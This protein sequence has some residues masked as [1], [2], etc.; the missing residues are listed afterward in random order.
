M[1]NL[2]YRS[3][4]IKAMLR[5]QLGDL[6][7]VHAL[8]WM[9]PLNTVLKLASFSSLYLINWTRNFVHYYIWARI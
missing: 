7:T 1:T 6:E 9:M 5:L 3:L 2:F 4:Y 8:S